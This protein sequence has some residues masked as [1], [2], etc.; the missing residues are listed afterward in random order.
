M[1]HA[2]NTPTKNNNVRS[3]L[4]TEVPGLGHPPKVLSKLVQPLAINAERVDVFEPVRFNIDAPGMKFSIDAKGKGLQ[5]H[6]LEHPP[7]QNQTRL[8]GNK[9]VSRLPCRSQ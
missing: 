2:L 1:R 5:A 3:G 7:L 9:H 8:L 6:Q 4:K